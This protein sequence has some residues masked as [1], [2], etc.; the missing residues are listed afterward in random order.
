MTHK[1]NSDA[2]QAKEEVF[3]HRL[4]VRI[5]AMNEVGSYFLVAVPQ[6][7]NPKP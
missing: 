5:H 1:S 7:L 2:E 6:S 3:F 4:K